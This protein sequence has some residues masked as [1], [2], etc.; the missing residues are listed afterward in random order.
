MKKK[1]ERKGSQCFNWQKKFLNGGR[2][3]NFVSDLSAIASS[4]WSCYPRQIFPRFP[5]KP[6]ISRLFKSSR[7]LQRK[8]MQ[9]TAWLYRRQKSLVYLIRPP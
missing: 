5:D 8:G 3:W 6:A 2:W 9:M 7:R 4:N 1:T